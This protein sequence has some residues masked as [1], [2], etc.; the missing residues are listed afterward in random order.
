MFVCLVLKTLSNGQ[1]TREQLPTGVKV[2]NFVK[3]TNSAGAA[4][5]GGQG[6]KP[7]QM[8]KQCQGAGIAQW[9]EHR[10]RD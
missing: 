6:I 3:W 10:T 9:L 1:T 4:A 2:L 5:Y 7:R 8:D